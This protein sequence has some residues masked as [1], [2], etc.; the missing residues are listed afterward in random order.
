MGIRN[1]FYDLSV[2]LS[3]AYDSFREDMKSIEADFYEVTT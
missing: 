1:E 2:I 3:T